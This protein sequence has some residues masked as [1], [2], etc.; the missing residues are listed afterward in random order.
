MTIHM[1][2][3]NGVKE[4]TF[5]YFAY[6]SCMCPVDLKRSLGESTHSYVVGPATLPGYRLGFFRRSERRQCGVLDVVKDSTQS[7][8][9]VLYRLPQRLSHLLDQREVG[10]GHET[11]TVICRGQSYRTTRTYTVHHKLTQEI[12]PNDWYLSVVLR[13]A[14]TCGLPE[15]YCWQLLHHMHHL[16]QTQKASVYPKTA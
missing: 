6:G 3:S 5:Y 7:V 12:A 9:G 13:G 2:S 4:S 14:Y 15:Q 1:L 8:E 10:Y 11:V 16:Q